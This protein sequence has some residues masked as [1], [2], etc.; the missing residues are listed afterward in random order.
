MNPRNVGSDAITIHNEHDV[1]S[2]S[3]CENKKKLFPRNLLDQTLAWFRQIVGDERIMILLASARLDDLLKR[4]LQSTMLHQGGSQ[5]S[6][7]DNDRPLG[8]FSSRIL[9]AYR[10]GLIDRDYESFLQSLRKLRN[11]AAHAAEHID[12]ATSPHVDRVVHLHSL[13]SK[14]PLWETLNDKPANP[15]T[16]PAAA[17]FTALVLAVF[18][19]ECAVLSAKLFSVDTVC[20]FHLLRMMPKEGS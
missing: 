15:K 8:T 11:D 14:S 12:L 2:A 5:D 13:A 3:H 20:G 10:L 16:E 19:A 17:L 18:N 1:E 6:L 4:L 9:L 7:F